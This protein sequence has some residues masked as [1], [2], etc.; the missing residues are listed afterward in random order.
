M[1]HRA[2]APA[3]GFRLGRQT[4]K[5]LD[6]SQLNEQNGHRWNRKAETPASA[7][8]APPAVFGILG[9]AAGMVAVVKDAHWCGA[10][11][12]TLSASGAVVGCYWASVTTGVLFVNDF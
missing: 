2:S 7:S 11:V 9:V 5:S 3:E 6:L 4:I 8:S 12:V 10:L 1:L